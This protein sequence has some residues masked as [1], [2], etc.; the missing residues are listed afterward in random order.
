MSINP[1]TILEF[2]K[3]AG[4]LNS[5]TWTEIYSANDNDYSD[6]IMIRNTLTT[7]I[8]IRFNEDD[9]AN[10]FVTINA[11]SSFVVDGVKFFKQRGKII[12][13]IIVPDVAESIRINL[14]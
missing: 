9:S 11:G 7:R 5:E 8:K 6:S 13:A 1:P 10:K 12:E 3:L 2:E 14:M 4:D